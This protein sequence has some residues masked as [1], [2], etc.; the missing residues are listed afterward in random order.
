VLGAL[1]LGAG[2]L[3]GG[4]R[5][6]PRTPPA[7]PGSPPPFLVAAVV[8]D[9]ERTE[10]IDAYG[11]V[12]GL[13]EPG[14]AGEP[15]IYNPADRQAAGSVPADTGIVARA[16]IGDRWIPF[17]DADSV[18]QRYLPGTNSLR[19]VAWFDGRKFSAL[20]T[21]GGGT[22]ARA[23][24]RWLARA[25]PL[26]NV[27][28]G[29]AR[30]MY[31]RSLLVLRALSDRRT[32]AV[33]A[34][35]RDGW[36]YVWPRD[37]GA[38]AIALASSG[39]RAEARQIVSFLQRLDLEAAARFRGTGEPVGGRG[40]EGDAAG[41]V[42]AAAQS[43]GLPRAGARTAWRGRAD[44]QEGGPG[45][46]LGNAIASRSGS[47][48]IRARF[49]TS[50]GL[51]RE[52]DNTDSGLDSAAAW[53]VQPFPRPA[54][55][56]LARRTLLRLVADS[57]RFGIVPS[58]DWA[59]GDDPWTAPTAWAAWSMAALTH[60]DECRAPRVSQQD[61]G[62]A[63]RLMSEL[64]RAATPAGL[65]PERVDVHSGIPRS[66]TPLA[67]SHAFAILALRELWPDEKR[68]RC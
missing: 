3:S 1:A 37:A 53:T 56:P 21:A 64:R 26:G 10:A 27:A 25:R 33:A 28:P 6:D 30:V 45:D 7:L 48:E 13:W 40:G 36:A 49:A 41:W 47:A 44:Y 42:A 8:G 55:Y 24:R 4:T 43:V 31:R 54:L 38:V 5:A 59:G 51:A 2:L 62:A 20:R 57:S 15:L 11:D 68:P 65:L 23:D 12:V 46:Y 66:T 34:G 60:T 35:P 61:R 58:E 17:W 19:T 50:R 32:G 18:R 63:L 16:H 22:A 14:P 39:Y 52:A 9:G 67:W 29:W